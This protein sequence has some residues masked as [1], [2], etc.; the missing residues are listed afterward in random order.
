MKAKLLMIIVLLISY[1]VFSQDIYQQTYLELDDVM[2]PQKSYVCRATSSVKLLPGF[3]YNPG[4]GKSMNI[5][6]DRYSVLPPTEGIH[7]GMNPSDDGVVGALP[8]VFNVSNSGAAVYSVKIETPAAIG[9]LKPDLSLVYNNQIGNGA[10][11]WSWDLSGVSS[12]VRIGQT[13]YHDGKV[14]DVDFINDRYLMD[15]QRLMLVEGSVYG[16]NKSEYKTEIDNMDKIVSYSNDKS[17]E[18]FVVWKNDGTIWEYGATD[19]SRVETKNDNKIILKWMLSKI[20]DR[21]GNAMIFRY[22]KDVSQGEAYINSILYTVNEDA[23]VDAA[24]KVSFVYEKKQ[25]DSCSGYV[26]GNKVS[27]DRLLKNIL[28]HN[29]RTGK[30]IFDYSMEYYNPGIYGNN[31]FIYHRLKSIGLKAG[32]EKINPTRILW[33]AEDKHYDNKFQSYQLNKSVFSD[34]VPF[35]GDFDGDG[36][37][38]VLLVPYKVQ[39]AYSGDVQGKVYLNNR[40]GGFYDTPSMSIDLPNNLDWIYVVDMNGDACDD[41]I[42][43]EFNYDAGQEDDEDVVKLHFYMSKNGFFVNGTT[44]SY[45]YNVA[46]VSGK[47]TANDDAGVLVV[48]AYN[49]YRKKRS[50]EYVRMQGDELE[51]IEMSNEGDINDQEADYLALDITGDGI[52]ELMVLYDGGYKVF[53]MKQGDVCAFEQYSEGDEMSKN[54]YIFPNDFNGDGKADILYYE[55]SRQWK[56]AFS[57]GNAFSVPVSCN[58]T[59]LLK[60]VALNSKDRYKYSLKEM[61]EPSVTIRTGDFDGDGVADVGVLKNEAGNHYLMMGLKP[62]VKPDNTCVFAKERRY[63]MPINYSH[64]TVHIGRFLSQENVSILSGLPRN[65]LSSQ[66]AYITSLY[67]QTAFYGVERIVD[68]MGNVRG[69]SYDYLMQRNNA[70]EKFY[71]CTNDITDNDIRRMPIPVSALRTDTVYSVNGNPIVTKY[72]YY[73]ALIHSKGHGFMGFE[74]MTTRMYLQGNLFEKK[75]LGY[76]IETL[77]DYCMIL[78]AYEKKYKGEMQML[79]D[80]SMAFKKYS[81]SLNDKVVLPVQ[82]H[83]YESVFNPDKSGDIVKLNVV[84]YNYASDMAADDKYESVVECSSVVKGFTDKANTDDAA[85]CQYI[86]KVAFTYKNDID[87]WI[88][89]RPSVIYKYKQDLQKER[90]G[91]VKYLVYDDKI[92]NLIIE[93]TNVPNCNGN[94]SDP[95]TTVIEYGYDKVGNLVRQSFLSPSV[96]HKRMV[97]SEY[98]DSYGYLYKT[99]SV[100]EL[101]REIK[102]TYDADYGYMISTMDYNGFVTINEKDPFAIDDVITLPDGMKKTHVIRWARNNEHSPSDASYYTWEKSTGT[103]ERMVFY[104]KSGAELRQVSFDINGKAIYVDKKYDDYGNLIWESLPYYRSDE[105]C[106]VSNVYDNYNRLVSKRFPNGLICD[107]SYDGNMIISEYVSTNGDRKVKRDTYNFMGWMVGAEDVGGNE[108]VYEYYCDGLVKS[109]AIAK[110]PNSKITVTYDNLRNKKTLNDPNY[111]LVSYQYDALGN[112]V[113]V[114]NPKGDVVE[115]SYDA[116][117]RVLSKSEKGPMVQAVTTQWIYDDAKGRNG[118]LKKVVGKNHNVEYMYDSYLRL[119]SVKETIKGNEYVT[120]YTYDPANRIA[121]VT[122][123]SG[124]FLSKV[125]SNTGY[126]KEIYDENTLLWR[127]NKTMA[128]GTVIDY[129]LGNGMVTNM[130]YDPATCL[131]NNIYTHDEKKNVQNLEYEYDDWGNMVSRCQHGGAVLSEEFEYDDFDRLTSIRLNGKNISSMNYDFQGNIIEKKERDVKVLYSTHYEKSRPNAIAQAKTDDKKMFV[132]F[133]RDM[134]FSGFDNLTSVKQ[135]D[136]MLEIEY[137]NDNRRVHMNAIVDGKSRSKTYVGDCE[138]VEENGSRTVVTYI[139]GPIGVFAVCAID[140]KGNKTMN[141]IHKDNLGSWNVITDED[142]N[143]IQNVAFD[144]WGNV[145]NGSDWSLLDNPDLIYDRGFTGHEHLI[146]FGLINMN[147]RVYDPMMSMMLSPDNNIQF[148]KMSQ[149]FNRYSYCLNNPMKYTDPTGEWVESVVMGIVGGAANLVMNA[150]NVDTFGEGALVFGVG[151]VKGFLTEYTAGQSWFIQVGVQTLMAGVTSGVNQ[152]VA[153]GDGS[154]KFSGDDWNSI[155]TAA[156]Y[157]L[158]NA[159]VKNIMFIYTTQPAEDQYAESLFESCYHKE[160]AY[161]VTSSVAHG[162]GCWFSGKPLLTSMRFKDVGFDLKMLGIIAKRMLCSYLSDSEFADQA[163]RQRAQE[164][165]E[166]M[167]AEIRAEDPDYPYFYYSYEVKGICVDE[168]RLYIIGDVFEMLP[169]EMFE[170]YPKPYLEEVVSYPFS[171]SLFKTL[172]FNDNE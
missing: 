147:G 22:D 125:F 57:K 38:D 110:N 103:A 2:N 19:D 128:D 122:Y 141:Y 91:S 133:S 162:V 92:P 104:H 27:N 61:Q 9:A 81:C 143:V 148:P 47:F 17:P 126:E 70:Q 36:Y 79:I 102:C 98:A 39:D 23:G 77:K 10:L 48:E 30:I 21:N 168:M 40:D 123:P 35:V 139:N 11:G 163:I 5:E 80:K 53:K 72:E 65:P 69:F 13:E 3:S 45:E 86:D 14:T 117:G 60:T 63:Y 144:A 42:V 29:N 8:G 20:Y 75:E 52:A 120:S 121:A 119:L 95:L 15:G 151:F 18:Y 124:L 166:S 164:I 26:Y 115:F 100:D 64:Q 93:E 107:I 90:I 16:G 108:I 84:D 112:V 135:G 129:Q 67:P 113:K 76:D 132:G 140:E 12:I 165:K 101:G 146:A 24:F 157:S 71:T 137:G 142:A 154:F 56:I 118:V 159:L 111:G 82:M 150:R 94:L 106:Y 114:T 34:N 41:V 28:I 44:Y 50:L 109:A 32:E 105:K 130:S 134:K 74:K 116:L 170:L 153:V 68:G 149:N 49:K 37:S 96:E 83:S 55:T 25:Y 172:F 136:D 43:Y 1:G 31:D 169:G 99:K 4:S 6:L 54:S 78:P 7:G 160:L 46:L 155:K 97:E 33:N 89:N 85:N 156:H 161:S 51:K 152:M 62:Y 58:N 87:N 59:N 145:R 171:Y 88:I 73:N 131:V 138:F 66:K 158:G 167:L 127:T